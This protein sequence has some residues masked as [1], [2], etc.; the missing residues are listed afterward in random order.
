MGGHWSQCP[1]GCLALNGNHFEPQRTSVDRQSPR[2]G[3]RSGFCEPIQQPSEFDWR[4][5]V[6]TS[7][8]I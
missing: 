8:A 7:P 6:T 4:H 5:V 2:A 3:S 1:A